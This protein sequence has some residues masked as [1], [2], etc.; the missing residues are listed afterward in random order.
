MATAN[1]KLGRLIRLAQKQRDL[2][3]EL[4]ALEDQRKAKVKDLERI[5]GGYQSEGELPM[6]MQEMELTSFEMDDGSVVSIDEEL[7]PPSMAANSKNREPLLKWLK[8]NKHG[9]AIKAA[10]TVSFSHDDPRKALVEEALSKIGVPFDYFETMHP[11][12]LAALLRELLEA[13]EEVPTDDLGIFIYKRAKVKAPK[14]G[15]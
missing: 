3:K 10:T 13:G 1:S 11:Q 15:S 7:K 14:G 2:E 12:T 5:A 8:D 9:D 4:D 6:A